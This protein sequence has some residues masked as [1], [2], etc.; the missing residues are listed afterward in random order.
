MFGEFILA[1]RRCG[2]NKFARTKTEKGREFWKD[3][4]LAI[5]TLASSRKKKI[6]CDPFRGISAPEVCL[7]SLPFLFY[8]RILITKISRIGRLS[9]KAG[10]L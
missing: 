8:T 4:L 1:R 2:E 7:K 10:S 6:L 5:K 9:A 3:F